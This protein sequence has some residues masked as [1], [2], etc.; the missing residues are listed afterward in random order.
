LHVS[1]PERPAGRGRPAPAAPVE[2]RLT[3]RGVLASSLLLGIGASG[4]AWPASGGSGPPG[5]KLPQTPH[6]HL[7]NII[8]MQGSLLE[9]DVPWWFTA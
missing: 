1:I 3:R 4:V 7:R 9:E 6:E 5:L 8:R 2:P